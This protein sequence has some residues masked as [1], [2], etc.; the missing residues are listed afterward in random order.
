MNTMK[1]SMPRMIAVTLIGCLALTAM[2]SA[3]DWYAMT[4][5]TFTTDGGYPWI[6]NTNYN[7]KLMTSGTPAA[8]YV[9][10]ADP[11]YGLSY[12]NFEQFGTVTLSGS[13]AANALAGLCSSSYVQVGLM[14]EAT[15]DNSEHGYASW[16]FNDSVMI[17]AVNGSIQVS[18][19]DM[20]GGRR[21][22]SITFDGTKQLDYQMTVDFDT[23]TASLIVNNND[24]SGWSSPV[25][26]LFGISDWG[27]YGNPGYGS[28]DLTQPEDYTS[29][30]LFA[31]IYNESSGLNATASFGDITVSVDGLAGS[32]TP[33]T[34]HSTGAA[35]E[36]FWTGSDNSKVLEVTFQLDNGKSMT[37]T[38]SDITVSAS[39]AL[40]AAMASA[41]VTGQISQV[42]D[43]DTDGY[44]FDAGE[45]LAL[46]IYVGLDPSL[47]NINLWHNDG[48]GWTLVDL[49]AAGMTASLVEGQ[50]TLM[51][52][53]DFS[54]YGVSIPEPTSMALLGLGGLALLRRRRNRKAA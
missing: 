4:G 5:G 36:R 50:L 44:A 47:D 16:Q 17:S 54:S 49:D 34:V 18:D 33:E 48:S 24:D 2:A 29:A 42:W 28:F 20:A 30:A 26:T 51:G 23:S 45:S 13:F 43:F 19:Y 15:I 35:E 37:L 12:D 25:S 27:A 3:G 8:Q 10:A 1:S 7:V 40:A 14:T 21:S 52:V 22:S 32:G 31:N 11:D 39:S 38:P 6:G 53:D 9:N 46:S 41:G